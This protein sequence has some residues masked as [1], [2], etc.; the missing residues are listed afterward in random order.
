MLTLL[1]KALTWL[2]GFLPT[3]LPTLATVVSNVSNNST[4]KYASAT[5]ASV[6]I[7]GSA[8]SADVAVETLKAQQLSQ[9]RGWWVTA[10]EKPLLFYLCLL[11]FGAVMLDSTFKFHWGIPKLPPPYDN[12]EGLVLMS[13]V[14]VI[15]T[16][17]L[18]NKIVGAIW[19]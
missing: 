13:D 11:H 7:Q 1:L 10:L 3:A 2:T 17:A 8:Q 4:V 9:D 12:Y 14:I 19:K 6:A 5:S 16:G 18:T 15:S